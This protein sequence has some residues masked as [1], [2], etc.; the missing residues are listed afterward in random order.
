VAKLIPPVVVKGALSDSVQPE[1]DVD[2]E[3]R[4]R[5]WRSSDASA[6]FEAYS[7]PDIQR[8][9]FRRHETE[10]DAEE[11]IAHE[12]E[13]WSKERSASWAVVIT[14]PRRQ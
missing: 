10:H 9:H 14:S 3:L 12:I 11:W 8:Y 2:H 6:V 4:L 13:G 5:P 1:L 7:S